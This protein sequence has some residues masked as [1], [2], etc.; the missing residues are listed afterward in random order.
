MA[1]RPSP[2]SFSRA[3]GAPTGM[4]ERLATLIETLFPDEKK[5]QAGWLK[6]ATFAVKRISM[7]PPPPPAS[8]KG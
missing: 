2:A 1:G 8:K 4:P 5:R 7:T 6:P 3:P